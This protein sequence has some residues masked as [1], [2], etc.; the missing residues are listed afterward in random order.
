MSEFKS[1]ITN[2]TKTQ[3]EQINFGINDP[4]G[5]EVGAKIRTWETD[6]EPIPLNFQSWHNIEPGHYFT[7]DVHA[8]RNGVEY[9]AAQPY[10]YFKTPSE[11]AKAIE[12][13]LTDAKKRAPKIK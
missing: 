6:F 1:T 4:R 3:S 10:K 7:L 8:T 9:G 13:Y 5:R 11:R 2:Q 12:R